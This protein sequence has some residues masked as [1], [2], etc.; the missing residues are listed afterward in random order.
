MIYRI[1]HYLYLDSGTSTRIPGERISILSPVQNS[2]SEA[3]C[4]QFSSYT[5]QD[6]FFPEY[7]RGIVVYQTFG[8]YKHRRLFQVIGTTENEWTRHGRPVPPLQGQP[9]RI[10]FE[11]IMGEPFDSDMAVDDV[12]LD[13]GECD[14]TGR[15]LI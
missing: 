4:L 9:Y 3:H 6:K 5:L 8:R 1:E 11:A 13:S 7:M 2:T 15:H 12:A 14:I 10:E